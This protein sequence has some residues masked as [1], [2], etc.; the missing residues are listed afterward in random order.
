MVTKNIS[1]YFVTNYAFLQTIVISTKL[2]MQLSLN[3]SPNKN[4]SKQRDYRYG[5]SRIT[6]VVASTRRPTTITTT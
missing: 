3:I 1:L 6:A 5:C 4:P 2:T